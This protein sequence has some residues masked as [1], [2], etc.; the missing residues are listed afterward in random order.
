[1]E[2]CVADLS[3][4]SGLCPSK[5]VLSSRGVSDSEELDD[6]VVELCEIG[7]EKLG[8]KCARLTESAGLPMDDASSDMVRA[9]TADGVAFMH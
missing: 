8:V 3:T 9:L 2:L 7:L 6:E 5:V 1:M 4:D